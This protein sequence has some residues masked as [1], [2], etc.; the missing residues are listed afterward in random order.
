MHEPDLVLVHQR[1]RVADTGD[2]GNLRSRATPGHLVRGVA[3]EEIR[4][5]TT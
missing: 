1:G 3:G 5:L 4:L 2:L